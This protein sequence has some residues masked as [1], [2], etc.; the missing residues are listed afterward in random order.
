MK[1]DEMTPEQQAE[2]EAFERVYSKVAEYR[3]KH[4]ISWGGPPYSQA[5]LDYANTEL[6][7]EEKRPV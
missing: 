3:V 7:K 6:A 5:E 1:Q 2:Y 4:K